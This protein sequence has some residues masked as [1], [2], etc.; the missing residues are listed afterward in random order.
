[1]SKLAL[2][3][4]RSNVRLAEDVKTLLDD[5]AEWI[6]SEI[7]DFSNG[8][9]H[10]KYLKSL[11]GKDVFLFQSCNSDPNKDIMELLIMIHT[12]HLASAR[13]ITAVVPYIY[14]SRQDRKSEPR[15]PVTISLMANLIEASQADRVVTV[16]LHSPQSIAAF[17]GRTKID[18]L[19]SSQMFG[20]LIKKVIRGQRDKW[21]VVSPDAGGL[22]RAR[23]Y[24]NSFDLPLA[25]A[26]KY[27]PS[28]NKSEVTHIVGDVDGMNCIVVDD[29]IDTGGSIIKL[30]ESLIEHGAQ[31]IIVLAT[32]LILSKD[33][34][35]NL[36]NSP[37]EK[38]YG[39]D[40][41]H[42]EDLPEKFEIFSLSELLA[43]VVLRIHE[44]RSVGVL[45]EKF[46]R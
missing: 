6:D 12:A 30:V 38:I 9:I 4:G 25:F 22:G 11:R 31:R 28:K 46:V 14:G 15:T 34:I 21:S 27:R 23:Y 33:A 36:N 1:M 42:H 44:D 41:I 8:E 5:K 24:S 18:N 45:F 17:N 20:N 43:D 35:E 3:S 39:T 13:R 7:C 37:I 32:H 29:M 16:S 40:G 19:T 26:N 2:V 10:V